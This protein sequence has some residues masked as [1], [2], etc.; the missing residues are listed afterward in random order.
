MNRSCGC[1]TKRGDILLVAT[2]EGDY[3]FIDTIENRVLTRIPEKQP[4]NCL[5]INE[6]M[7]G[8]YTYSIHLSIYISLFHLLLTNHNLYD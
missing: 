2:K 4:V 5:L 3:V 7:T 6:S 1:L 8:V